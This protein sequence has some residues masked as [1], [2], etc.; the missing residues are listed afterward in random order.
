M[1]KSYLLFVLV[2]SEVDANIFF[3]IV[4]FIFEFLI[5]Y[6][7]E[8][9]NAGQSFFSCNVEY[10][11]SLHYPSR[12][13]QGHQFSHSAVNVYKLHPCPVQEGSGVSYDGIFENFIRLLM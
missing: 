2:L 8:I 4:Y 3:V 12:V 1:S 9:L 6:L 5:Y 10:V 13:M 7:L 11:H